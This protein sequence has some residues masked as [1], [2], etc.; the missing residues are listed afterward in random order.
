VA[1][2]HLT[3]IFNTVS[4]GSSFANGATMLV[5][6]KKYD[7][8][9]YHCGEVRMQEKKSFAITSLIAVLLLNGGIV[10]AFYFLTPDQYSSQSAVML[11]I[12]SLLTLSLWLIIAWVGGRAIDNAAEQTQAEHSA[13]PQPVEPEVTVESASALPTPEPK[14]VPEPD[15]P[16]APDETSA[17][18]ILAILQRKGRLIDFLQED[19]TAYEDAQIGAAVRTVH[20]GCNEALAETVDLVPVFQASEGSTVTIEPDF[21]S[22]AIRLVGSVTDDPPFSGVL[23]HKG[24]RAAGISLPE[25]TGDSGDKMIIAAAEVEL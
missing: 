12:A 15:L 25:R 10:A 19:L 24:W 16:E 14:P 4:D 21:D 23:R 18:Q 2:A 9:F 7:M 17:I 13:R 20:E 3:G 8:P 1:P 6:C 22:H 5:S 11:G